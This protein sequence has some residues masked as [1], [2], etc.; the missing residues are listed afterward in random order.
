MESSL[1]IRRGRAAPVLV[2][3]GL[4][5]LFLPGRL[6][7][8]GDAAKRTVSAPGQTWNGW[9]TQDWPQGGQSDDQRR[10]IEENFTGARWSPPAGA[11]I[12]PSASMAWVGDVQI[13]G[14]SCNET[15]T[16]NYI[17]GNPVA[18]GSGIAFNPH[19]IVGEVATAACA[20]TA[21]VGPQGVAVALTETG[22]VAFASP[23]A[24]KD[25]GART[26][27]T[28]PGG[29]TEFVGTPVVIGSDKAETSGRS[30]SGS[31]T[32]YAACNNP[33]PYSY[34]PSPR[35]IAQDIKVDYTAQTKSKSL[36]LDAPD[37]PRSFY[38]DS[39]QQFSFGPTLSAGILYFATRAYSGDFGN[40]GSLYAAAPT[41]FS[42]N[43]RVRF[44][45]GPG[46]TV[47]GPRG[48]EPPDAN[49]WYGATTPVAVSGQLV[50]V[51]CAGSAR[52]AGAP[53]TRS[54]PSTP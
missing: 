44:T 47:P 35:I 18:P 43:W 29:F 32:V 23:A 13:G 2:L 28:R 10:C 49:E 1:G 22:I 21:A 50:V 42:T 24:W 51:G 7:H 16:C 6:V 11:P 19:A 40:P 17:Y 31:F 45:I 53:G 39:G 5:I 46:A 25:Y 48:Q 33:D 41:D 36:T 14:L 20:G 12:Y 9:P 30:N 54:S 26:Y 37:G 3:A 52:T 15:G 34:N 8:A 27:L 38:M 4:L